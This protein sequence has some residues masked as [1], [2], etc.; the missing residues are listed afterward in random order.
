MDNQITR[1]Y[2]TILVAGNQ[3]DIDLHISIYMDRPHKLDLKL[4]SFTYIYI[5]EDCTW[6][7]FA[8]KELTSKAVVLCGEE[9]DRIC[10]E[11]KRIA[12]NRLAVNR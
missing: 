7:I 12:Q 5:G 6:H 10:I 8:S 3:A 1:K 2:L 9:A 4:F 11:G